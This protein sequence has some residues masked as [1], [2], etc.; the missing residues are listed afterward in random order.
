[1]WSTMVLK[2]F[3]D[4]H[5]THLPDIEQMEQAIRTSQQNALTASGNVNYCCTS[6]LVKLLED[7][8]VPD[9]LLECV[10]GWAKCSHAEGFN[11]IPPAYGRQPNLLWMY[12][13][14]PNAEAYKPQMVEVGGLEY[15]LP[16]EHN[17][18]WLCMT[19]LPS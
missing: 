3:N 8:R 9:Y 10:L 12:N 17:Q 1:M 5:P 2:K 13:M 19:L 7:A 18:W 15:H 6:D 16:G 14:L 11:F 4:L